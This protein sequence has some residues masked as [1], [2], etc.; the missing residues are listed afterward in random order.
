MSIEDNLYK[1]LAYYKKM[2][3]W[4]KKLLAG[5]VGIIPRNLL[6]GENYKKFFEEAMMLEFAPKEKIEEYQFLK[7]KN[8]LTH[9]YD[10]VP[11][12][13]DTWR[14]HGIKVKTIQSFSDFNNTIPQL[15]RET[16]QEHP[17]KFMSALYPRSKI[18]QVNT[19]GS[20]G[21]PLKL[22][23]LKNVSRAAEWAHMHVQWSRV[24]YKIG[25][26]I[27]TLRGDY[28]GKNR[29]YSY[30]PWRNTLILSSFL[31]TEKN[32]DYYL[33][34][35]ERYKIKFINAYPSS[36]Y[37][38]I[39]LSSHRKKEISSLKC[40]LLGSE[41]IFDWQVDRFADFFNIN[42]IYHW[43]GHGEQCALGGGCEVSSAYHFFPSY[44]YTEFI[45]KNGNVDKNNNTLCEITGSSFVNPLMP[46]IRYKTQD[47]C[48]VA[49]NEC[50]CGRNHKRVSRVIGRE[51][52][53]AVGFKGEKITLT[54]LI[55]GRHAAYF[56]HILKM[57]IIN[58]APG[59]LTVNVIPKMTFSDAHAREIEE[60]L[61]LKQGMPFETSVKIVREI[62]MT[63]RGKHRILLRKFPLS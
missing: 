63:K 30:D 48:V 52:E 61:S 26:R 15:T 32:A 40:I 24:G 54:A 57:Q 39:Q 58:S 36:L 56:N 38:L 22:Y 45:Y 33:E 17:D 12:Y 50:E 41:N 2:P 8:L 4:S 44:G 55:F 3:D 11:F 10:T 46:L 1:Y 49:N 51:Q 31:L 14:Q 62:E 59:K 9:C 19:G 28:I 18:L 37:N 23:Y 21:I 47:Y 27:A 7:I 42:K 5:P 6:L 43:Y 35:L 13:R 20:T 25:M 34:L 29:V 53:I 16:V 60:S